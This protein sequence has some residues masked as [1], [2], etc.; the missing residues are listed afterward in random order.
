MV[1]DERKTVFSICLGI[2][3]FLYSDTSVL[4]EINL[5][6]SILL[7]FIVAFLVHHFGGY[8]G[9]YGYDD[10]EYARLATN[11]THGNF[12]A[13]NHYSFRLVLVGLTALF[14]K[15]FGVNDLASA[16]PALLFSIGTLL[17]IYHILKRESWQVLTVGLALFAF[18]NWTFFYSDKLMP[19]VAVTFFVFLFSFVVYSYKYLPREKPGFVYSFLAALALFLGFNSKETV[20][21]VAPWVIWLIGTDVFLK[22]SLKFW[23]QFVAFSAAFLLGYLIVCQLAFGN[24]FERFHAIVSNSYLNACSYDQQPF[25]ETLKRIT[26]GLLQLFL[27]N[28]LLLGFFIIIPGLF[29]IPVQSF[30][31]AD[32]PKSFFIIASVILLVSS[33]FMSISATSYVPMCLDPRHYLFIV[34]VV[35]LGATFVFRD[36]F[37]QV[38]FRLVL[39][40]LLCIAFAVTWYQHSNITYLLYLPLLI[41]TGVS[42]FSKINDTRKRLFV[43]VMLLILLL[44]PADM[45]RYARKVDYNRQKAIVMEK[46][47]DKNEPCVVVTD[48]VQKRLGHYYSGFLSNARCQF[49]SY[50]EADTFHFR[51]NE[52]K[53]L[54]NNWYTRY[55]SGM[56][57]QDLP[58]YAVSASY[59]VFGDKKL[60]FYLYDLGNNKLSQQLLFKAE[61]NFETPAKFWNNATDLVGDRVFSGKYSEEL[62]EF[63]VCCTIPIDSLLTDSIKQIVVSPK[64]EILAVNGAECSL[65]I[66]ME[67]NGKQYFWKGFEL[68]KYIKSKGS[69]WRASVNEIIKSKEIRQNST[70]KIYIWNNKKN[71][72][73]IDDFQLNIFV[74][75]N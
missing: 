39:F 6:R 42:L 12:D 32:N 13:L 10:M 5:N 50:A 16:L 71:E 68:S 29:F 55:L 60:N 73:Y 49:I 14:Y 52:R 70:M 25:S 23:L 34:P 8:L 67:T 22:R 47:I 58:F 24:A 3:D 9:H 26:Y 44:Q 20:V 40:L 59:P 51:N 65:V 46:L 35:T 56:D 69:W 27:T 48:V 38:K 31:K 64:L 19:D 63:S 54:L 21:L 57:D 37:A 36:Y 74:V 62:G 43:S 41:V 4:K 1:C 17:L 15:L 33:N 75:K 30:L 7:F 45:M 2:S 11:L 53:Y 72:I 18:N 66:T 61:N 28:D